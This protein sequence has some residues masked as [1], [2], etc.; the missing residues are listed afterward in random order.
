M[1]QPLARILLLPALAL[2]AACATPPPVPVDSGMLVFWEIQPPEGD[3]AVAHLL[4]SIHLGLE[5]IDFDSAVRSAIPEASMMVY[6][7]APGAMDPQLVAVAVVEMGRLPAGQTLQALLSTET[8]EAFEKQLAEAGLSA[9]DLAGFKPW[10]AMFQ[11]LGL[12]MASAELDTS[13]GVEAQINLL[14][15]DIP[16]IGLETVDF[17]LGLFDALPM[18][19]QIFLLEDVLE[20][21]DEAADALGLM[22]AAW[23]AGDLALLERLI[24][25][26]ENN[27]Q[28]VLFHERVFLER[29]RNMAEGVADLLSEPGRYFVTLG[30]GHTLGAEGVP[31]LL[32]K[33]GFRVRRIPRT[34]TA[35]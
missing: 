2:L 33:E 35:P 25:P 19:T 32:E 12:S 28:L 15:G 1:R 26:A 14:A 11:L 23:R 34:E 13:L 16:A 5:P 17:Q 31:A 9:E 20:H 6:E 7:I 22:L 21:E 10:V 18:D 4:G 8:W 29:N 3:G 27:P 30:A 24:T